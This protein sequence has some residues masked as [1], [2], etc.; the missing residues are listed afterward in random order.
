MFNYIVNL[1]NMYYC[2]NYLCCEFKPCSWWGV[3]D[4]T[5]CNKVY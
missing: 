2:C 3:L 4:T 1:V 5:L